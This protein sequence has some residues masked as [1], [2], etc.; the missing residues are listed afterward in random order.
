MEYN[1][2]TLKQDANIILELLKIDPDNHFEY[3]FYEDELP[4]FVHVL[5][6]LLDGKLSEDEINPIF[7]R[8]ARYILQL[9]I[10][11]E[12]FIIPFITILAKRLSEENVSAAEM[13]E[14]DLLDST[15]H[16][17]SHEFFTLIIQLEDEQIRE[18]IKNIKSDSQ[19]LL[20]DKLYEAVCNKDLHQF[21]D[22][23]ISNNADIS[24]AA[25]YLRTIHSRTKMVADIATLFKGDNDNIDQALMNYYENTDN[26]PYEI[27]YELE[28]YTLE[29]CRE[30]GYKV[31][32][33]ITYVKEMLDECLEVDYYKRAFERMVNKER[34]DRMHYCFQGLPSSD[35]NFFED[36]FSV[37][38]T[39]KVQK[40]I[41]L[42]NAKQ[43]SA[44]YENKNSEEEE[45]A[46]EKDEINAIY[47]KVL[48]KR[49][50]FKTDI[51]IDAMC[52]KYLAERIN[53]G[54][55]RIE[56]IKY[57]FFGKGCKPDN[58]LVWSNKKQELV[59]FM[60]YFIRRKPREVWEYLDKYIV[61]ENG[62]PLF[63]EIAN[64]TSSG[65]GKP[66]EDF[67]K[68]LT[69]IYQG[70]AKGDEILRDFGLD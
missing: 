1:I 40:L 43:E 15:P 67:K 45:I 3:L 23:L 21:T 60:N 35:S 20:F 64:P 32:S 17:T 10:L 53:D 8:S 46:E 11:Y 63:E 69:K 65:T 39:Y 50:I 16:I 24:F 4:K 6:E 59:A 70:G 52:K 68:D 7:V 2:E 19:V 9:H 27:N 55:N 37:S 28:K 56:E 29:S 26:D 48:K 13:L 33:S 62:D 42:N 30:L 36:T 41:Y 14:M 51:V 12:Y 58:K 38:K 34:R 18:A 47:A 44:I 54:I 5:K 66:E 57:V 25:Q 61:N 31:C 22:I 49:K